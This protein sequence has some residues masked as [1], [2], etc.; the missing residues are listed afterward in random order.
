MAESA[1]VRVKGPRWDTRRSRASQPGRSGY[2]GILPRDGLRPK[3]PQ[4]LAG[5]RIDPPP[6]L[7]TASGPSPEATAAPAPPLEPAGVLL[8]SHGLR[9][10]PQ[11]GLSVTDLYPNSHV[12]VFPSTMAPAALSLSTT[13][14]SWSGTKCSCIFEPK[15]VRIPRVKI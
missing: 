5:A 6:S 9:V 12:A 4:K 15:V 10:T 8:G 1:T 13:T 14:S 3:I 7:P 2:I 11:S